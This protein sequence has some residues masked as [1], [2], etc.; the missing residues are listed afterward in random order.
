MI[1]IDDILSELSYRT[2]NGVVDL[3][4][5]KQIRELGKILRENGVRNP[6][7]IARIAG[8]NYRIL[9]EAA[10]KYDAS[11]VVKMDATKFEDFAAR[12]FSLASTGSKIPNPEEKVNGVALGHGQELFDAF[13]KLGKHDVVKKYAPFPA[14]TSDWKEWTGKGSDTPKT[15][16][17]GKS[18]RI[19]VKRGKSQLMSPEKKE[20]K[21]TFNAA[22][23]LMGEEDVL[24]ADIEND[25]NELLGLTEGLASAT[26]TSQ[27][28]EVGQLT[29]IKQDKKEF[30]AQQ[31]EKGE[32]EFKKELDE[33]NEK[34]Y[35][36]WKKAQASHKKVLEKLEQMT[37]SAEFKR[38]M[39]FEAAT[40]EVKF[41]SKSEGRADW[42]LAVAGDAKNAKLM[43]I[44]KMTDAG[45]S[46][47]LGK[48][49]F[50]VTMK[51]TGYGPSGNRQGYNFYSSFRVQIGDIMDKTEKLNEIAHTIATKQHLL[52]E[53]L[54]DD[55]I[56][57]V[58]KGWDWL[59]EKVTQLYEW[60]KE[61][62][63]NALKL[64]QE[65]IDGICKVIG[66]E[67]QVSAQ[68]AFDAYA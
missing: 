9:Q 36:I 19:S 37:G 18:L 66:V 25:I 48:V 44:K 34:A 28:L 64:V 68:V 24:T 52:T 54:L 13:K 63:Q 2:S 60:I 55:L 46:N 23:K 8:I 59:V 3:K 26:R 38:A 16:I 7:D 65:G 57:M 53:G 15:D 35:K 14:T 43:P 21:A 47:L 11:N 22:M 51:S 4:N 27:G 33:Q 67:P 40:G 50:T 42:I 32:K 10:G 30:N 12:L 17:S 5:P 29:A 6:Y 39:V 58:K 61:A 45:I 56:G 49:K 1:S 20:L 41:G 62:G 31:R